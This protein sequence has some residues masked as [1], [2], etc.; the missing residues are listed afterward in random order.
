M[1]ADEMDTLLATIRAT[2]LAIASLEAAADA[3]DGEVSVEIVTGLLRAAAEHVLDQHPFL[4]VSP[5]TLT[6]IL[7]TIV[8][9]MRA[10]KRQR[11]LAD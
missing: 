5:A 4:M 7:A 9:G 1:T 2:P 10:E 11:A 3:I 8:Q 6:A